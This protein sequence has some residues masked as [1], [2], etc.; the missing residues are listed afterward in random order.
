MRKTRTTSNLL[1][2]KRETGFVLV[3]VCKIVS[4]GNDKESNKENSTVSV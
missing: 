2:L 1:F 3:K 4:K